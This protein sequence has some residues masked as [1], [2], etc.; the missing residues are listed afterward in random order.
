MKKLFILLF[1]A[2]CATINIQAQMSDAAVVKY[3]KD[4]VQQGKSQQQLQRELVVKGVTKEQVMRLKDQYENQKKGEA[5]KVQAATD[6]ERANPESQDDVKTA[7]EG[8]KEINEGGIRVFGRNIFTN[9]NLTF[10]PNMNIP[11]PQNYRLG[12]GDQIVIE[13]WGASEANYTQKVSPEGYINIPQVGPL[14]VNGMTVQA[15]STLIKE[16]LAKIYSGMATANVDLG[17]NAKVTLGQIRTIQVNIMGE[18]ARPGTYA[19]SS[20]STAFHALYRAGGVS[21]LGTLRGIRVLRGGKTISIID[22]YDYI[23]NGH[24]ATD[25][26]LEDGDMIL[27]P[28]YENLV[29]IQG[30]VKRPMWYEMKKGEKLAT[31]INY[32]GGFV[33]DAYSR[34][35]TIERIDGQQ[36]SVATVDEDHYSSF[37]LH[38][39]DRIDVSAILQR[40]TNRV[41]IKGSVYRPGFY[42]LGSQINTIKDLVA[43][44]DGPLEEAF[45]DQ[46]KM[47][48]E[49]KNSK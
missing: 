20:F 42:E 45:L 36:K 43:K 18:V 38:D 28:T 13:V 15:A 23:I 12:P 9:A 40:Y 46:M 7:M 33:S 37:S 5:V 29:E 27:V 32:A 30:N 44:A 11:T 26:R 24:S 16:S 49:A 1:F 14:N 48:N 25:I 22:V 21:S 41:E 47:F 2:I 8:T 17:T 39:G 3:V 6:V 19:L 4:G 31:I 35:I 34:T 10:E